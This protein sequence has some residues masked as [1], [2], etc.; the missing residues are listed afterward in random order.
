MT[1]ATQKVSRGSRTAKDKCQ[2][3]DSQINLKVNGK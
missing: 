3:P 2:R 1:L